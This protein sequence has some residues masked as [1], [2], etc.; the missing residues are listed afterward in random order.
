MINN[1]NCPSDINDIEFT[2]NVYNN[3]DNINNNNLLNI[4][5]MIL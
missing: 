2:Y 3:S 5:Q 4:C 1:A